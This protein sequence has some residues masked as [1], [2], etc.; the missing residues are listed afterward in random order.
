[1]H[2]AGPYTRM[3][4]LQ[5]LDMLTDVSRTLEGTIEIICGGTECS[6]DI[7]MRIGILSDL[8]ERLSD[9]LRSSA[10]ADPALTVGQVQDEL[11]SFR[12]LYPSTEPGGLMRIW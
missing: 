8:V 3:L 4:T 9:I 10:Q 12:E 6:T 5:C 1:M 11:A 7:S 2:D